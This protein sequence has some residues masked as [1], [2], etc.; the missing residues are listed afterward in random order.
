MLAAFRSAFGPK[1]ACAPVQPPSSQSSQAPRP[2]SF[3]APRLRSSQRAP[4]Q[5]DYSPFWSNI[6]NEERLRAVS[7]NATE[8]TFAKRLARRAGVQ[9]TVMYAHMPEDAKDFARGM[10]TQRW[11]LMC[12]GAKVL[13]FQECVPHAYAVAFENNIRQAHVAVSVAGMFTRFQ[14]VVDSWNGNV[15]EKF[16]AEWNAYVMKNRMFIPDSNPQ[17]GR[18]YL[19]HI[20]TRYIDDF[21]VAL[22]IMQNQLFSGVV[23]MAMPDG[24]HHAVT[25]TG[26]RVNL[27]VGEDA[28]NQQAVRVSEHDFVN[29]VIPVVH[30]LEVRG[31]RDEELELPQVEGALEELAGGL[32]Q[33]GRLRDDVVSFSENIAQEEMTAEVVPSFRPPARD[34]DKA[35]AIS[36]SVSIEVLPPPHRSKVIRQ[37]GGIYQAG[38]EACPVFA[39]PK[40]DL[41]AAAAFTID[42]GDDFHVSKVRT[43][44][45]TSWGRV[46]RPNLGWVRLATED[47]EFAFLKNA[48]SL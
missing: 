38:D 4:E 30:I 28:A 29:L 10:S 16:A 24:T 11:A 5:T 48:G 15:A 7:Q 39:N 18:R 26:S 12:A 33:N 43:V 40:E 14:T 36:S 31:L 37:E 25:A 27:L 34:A 32:P 23:T 22:K 21:Q 13:G 47:H 46:I 1:P 8:Q 41:T 20:A 42:A 45:G 3:Q 17:R 2:R 6:Y 44:K 35:A 19:T 9:E